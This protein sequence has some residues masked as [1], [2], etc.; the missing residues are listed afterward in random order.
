M[1]FTVVPFE[2][3]VVAVHLLATIGSCSKQ[4]VRRPLWPW[5]RSIDFEKARA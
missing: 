2:E 4:E 3:W 5:R 1:T